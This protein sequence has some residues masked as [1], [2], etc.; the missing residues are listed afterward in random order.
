MSSFSTPA[1]VQSIPLRGIFAILLVIGFYATNLIATRY[2]VL[3]GLTSLD[4]VALRYGVAGVVLMPYFCRLGLRDLGGIGWLKGICLCCLAGAP[5][6]VVFFYGLSFAPAAHGAVLNPGIVPSVV[7][8]SMVFLGRQSFSLSRALSLL[9][10]VLG[11]MLVTRS[12]F[13]TRG[14]VLFG[15]ILLFITGISW[16][17]F[18]LFAKLWELRPMQAAAVVSVISLLYLPPYLVF[19]HRGFESA[20]LTHVMSQAIFQGLVNS[21]AILYLLTYAVHKLG[22]QLTALF[23]P[24]VPVLTTLLAVPLLGEIPNTVQWTGVIVVVLGM[25]S[26]AFAAMLPR[27][28][29]LRKVLAK[30]IN[31]S[32]PPAA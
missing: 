21:I 23:S 32:G 16:G 7:F 25:L 3:N 13:S 1:P 12:S 11:L 29:E 5:Y 28:D 22:A 2:S 31:R 20:S 8:L 18:T 10:I 24:L 15:D 30:A 27:K 17:L 14:Q 9:L 4:L 26:A 19:Y 6:M